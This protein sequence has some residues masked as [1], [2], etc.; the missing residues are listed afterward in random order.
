MSKLDCSVLAFDCRGHGKTETE[1]ESDLSLNTLADDLS[2]VIGPYLEEY[3]IILVGHSMGGAVIT[4]F[5]RRNLVKSLTG[6]GV[7][8]KFIFANYFL[9][10][11]VVIDVVEG[12]AIDSL[13]YMN[14]FLTSRPP[15][16][17]SRKL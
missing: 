17:L 9:H 3:Q 14:S 8:I 15:S 13:A 7:L 4:E 10:R 12:S 1:D 2:F 16:F 6:Y 11:V 5:A